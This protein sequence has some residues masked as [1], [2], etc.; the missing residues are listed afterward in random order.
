MA[1][2]CVGATNPTAELE[3][4]VLETEPPRRLKRWEE[5]S[6][7]SIKDVSGSG[8]QRTHIC[9]PQKINQTAY[10]DVRKTYVAYVAELP[11]LAAPAAAC[12]FYEK[13]ARRP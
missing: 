4:K 13:A 2:T 1:A 5:K 12:E 7:T 10:A 9:R 6:K 11:T 8:V 3:K